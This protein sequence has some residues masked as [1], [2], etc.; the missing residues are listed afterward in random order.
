MRAIIDIR[1]RNYTHSV[2]K[3]IYFVNVAIPERNESNAPNFEC[4]QH[5]VKA[6]IFDAFE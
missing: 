2:R 1:T 3:C 5:D 4:Q 6:Y